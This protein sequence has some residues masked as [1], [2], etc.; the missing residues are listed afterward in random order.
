MFFSSI[1]Q[2]KIL[3][4]EVEI[5]LSSIQYRRILCSTIYSFSI[6]MINLDC[7]SLFLLLPPFH[8]E[9]CFY[10]EDFVP[11]SLY[12][13]RG[14]DCSAIKYTFFYKK[15]SL[16]LVLSFLIFL[17]ILEL[18]ASY[19]FH[20]KKHQNIGQ[21]KQNLVFQ[22]LC[23]LHIH[24]IQLAVHEHG[25]HN[26]LKKLHSQRQSRKC[27]LFE[28]FLKFECD[29]YFGFVMFLPR[30]G[31]VSYRVV[32]IENACTLQCTNGPIIALKHD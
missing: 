1:Y 12:V 20:R 13:D 11:S 28:Q 14:L 3:R 26:L 23:V 31:S 7:G 4:E 32:L 15:L 24:L 2:T 16:N 8:N 25:F 27:L 22:F 19:K 5:D 9:S 30:E 18:K 21:R 29:P 6:R 10:G 17:L